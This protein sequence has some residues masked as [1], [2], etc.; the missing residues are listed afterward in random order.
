MFSPKAVR[1]LRTLAWRVLVVVWLVAV[2]SLAANAETS[3]PEPET[4][5]YRFGDDPNG[6]LGW[7]DPGFDDSA[8]P[9]AVDS[10]WPM[11]PFNSDGIL[12]VRL[13]VPVPSTAADPLTIRI[14]DD[15]RHATLDPRRVTAEQIFV[16]G[17]LVGQDNYF[18]DGDRQRFQSRFAR[19]EAVFDLPADVTVPGTIVPGSTALVALRIWYAP[20]FRQAGISAG[21]RVEIDARRVVHLEA[22]ADRLT[23]LLAGSLG[24]A[25]PI[26]IAILGLG[27]LNF[28][29]RLRGRELLLSSSMLIAF[30]AYMFFYNLNRLAILDLPRLQYVLMFLALQIPSLLLP[31]ELMWSL[32]GLRNRTLKYAA[33]LLAALFVASELIVF[34]AVTSSPLVGWSIS[35]AALTLELFSFLNIGIG[36]WAIVRSK[37]NRLIACAIILIP[38]AAASD[39]AGGSRNPLIAGVTVN[40][41]ELASF[42]AE[43]GLFLLLGQRAWKAWR[44]RDELRAEF[45]AAREVQEQLIA[46]AV[47][48]PGFRIESA[49]APSKQVGG[50]FFRILPGV[51]GSVLVLT[52]DVSGKGLKAAMTVSAIMGALRGCGSREPA[53]VLAYLNQVLYGQIG[54]FVTCCAAR[55]AADGAM[56]IANAGN[57]APYCHGE[58]MA[59]EPGLPLGIIAEASYAETRHQLVPNDQ[60]TF[61]SDGVIEATSP[62]GELYGFERT[63]AI[64]NQSAHT[65]AETVKLFG[66]EDDITV[67]TLCRIALPESGA[68]SGVS[69]LVPA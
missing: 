23:L 18:P 69:L 15:A 30:P 65:I 55:I 44:V 63:Q 17:R 19:Q 51:D 4:V 59:I 8:W 48:L 3:K 29:L 67:L 13:H 46:P 31:L 36:A 58:E 57:P 53:E 56:T 21:N 60:L 49:Y 5:R 32:Y 27:L 10:R 42:I 7:A 62:T 50:D 68:S 61:V 66:Q 14:V 20:S 12:W 34:T 45:D 26:V 9:V 16:N 35:A 37:G 41:F 64:S 40:L 6:W 22:L 52:G 24:L 1:N 11:P 2:F 43:L 38:L 47:H 39:P 54:G 25:E 33:Y 28:W